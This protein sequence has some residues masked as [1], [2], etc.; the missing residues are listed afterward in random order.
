MT[1]E[2]DYLAQKVLNIYLDMKGGSPSYYH[3]KERRLAECKNRYEVFVYSDNLD[4]KN[5]ERFAK[6]I[7]VSVEELNIAYKVLSHI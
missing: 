4:G 7:G 6:E 3:E 5:K 2:L 1:T